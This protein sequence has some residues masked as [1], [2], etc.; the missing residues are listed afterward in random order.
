MCFI[1]IKAYKAPV[2]IGSYLKLKA[3]NVRQN[4]IKTSIEVLK[5]IFRAPLLQLPDYTM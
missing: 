2:V 5:C 1:A 4:K 3:F